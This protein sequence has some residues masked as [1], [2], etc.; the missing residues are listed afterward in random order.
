MLIDVELR[1]WD[2]NPK[3]KKHNLGFLNEGIRY[4]DVPEHKIPGEHMCHN[5]KEALHSL[6]DWVWHYGQNDFQ[7]K[8]QRS[9]MVGDVICVYGYRFKIDDFGFSEI[10]ETN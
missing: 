1:A 8:E 2:D 6:L 4:V 9:L 10:K 7:P 3:T 5:N